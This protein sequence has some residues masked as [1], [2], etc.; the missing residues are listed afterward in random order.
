MKNVPKK[1]AMV[2]CNFTILGLPPKNCGIH[3][4]PKNIIVKVNLLLPKERNSIK[5]LQKKKT[6]VVDRMT[7]LYSLHLARKDL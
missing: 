7:Y 6:G 5:F 1:N 2:Q 4:S 3:M